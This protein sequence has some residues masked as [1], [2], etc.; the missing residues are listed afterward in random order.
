MLDFGS[1]LPERY[2]VLGTNLQLFEANPPTAAFFLPAEAAD[3]RQPQKYPF[4][5]PNEAA[6]HVPVRRRLALL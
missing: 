6:L 2:H 1:A 5:L 3:Q 4:L